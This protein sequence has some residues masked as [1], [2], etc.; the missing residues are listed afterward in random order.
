MNLSVKTISV[1]RVSTLMIVG[2]IVLACLPRARS[3]EPATTGPG[4][5]AP[6]EDGQDVATGENAVV[7]EDSGGDELEEPAYVPKTV[8][9]LGSAC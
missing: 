7:V 3:Q 1:V 6:A 4:I 9:E 2:V 8:A 5:D